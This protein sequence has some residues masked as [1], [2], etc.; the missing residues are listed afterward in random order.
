M[1]KNIELYKNRQKRNIGEKIADYRRK[2]NWTQLELSIR[3]GITR[4]QISRIETGRCNP[5]LETLKRIEDAFD[6]P[7][8]VLLDDQNE[9]EDSNESVLR[10]RNEIVLHLQ[11]EL[12]QRDL[13]I[14]ELLIVE[15]VALSTADAL[16]S[17]R[18]D[19]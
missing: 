8:W 6:L 5:K 19:K 10:R 18:P 2:R 4:D 14:T 1:K 12:H 15:C 17:N 11:S 13:S 7:G 9:R 16:K 3:T